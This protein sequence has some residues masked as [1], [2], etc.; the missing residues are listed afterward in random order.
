MRRGLSG[1]QICCISQQFASGK[2][3][4]PNSKNYLFGETSDYMGNAKK[5]PEL[6]RSVSLR[7]L[8]KGT[9]LRREV[10][11]IDTT[12]EEGAWRGLLAN[13]SAAQVLTS[14]ELTDGAE[15]VG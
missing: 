5:R 10:Y 13:V 7:R 6:F 12:D 2:L 15:P 14:G 9:M 8:K 1:M 3:Q 4:F 11:R